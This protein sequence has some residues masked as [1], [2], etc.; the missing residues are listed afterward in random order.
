MVLFPSLSEYIDANTTSSNSIEPCTVLQLYEDTY[1]DFWNQ[2]IIRQTKGES[3]SYRQVT[4][5]AI[6]TEKEEEQGGNTRL[7]GR[8]AQIKN[9]NK[10][11]GKQP[12]LGIWNVHV[13]QSHITASSLNSENTTFLW[14]VDLSTPQ[15]VYASMQ[16]FLKAT[17]KYFDSLSTLSSSFG[18]APNNSS[19]EEVSEQIPPFTKNQLIIAAI[20]PPNTTTTTFEEKQAQCLLQ[21]HLH[22]FAAQIKATLVFVS[23]EILKEEDDA[24][25][26]KKNG[27]FVSDLSPIIHDLCSNSDEEKDNTVEF[28]HQDHDL[29]VI[30][31]V[32]LRNASCP[33][34]WDANTQD[35]QEVFPPTTEK[36]SNVLASP[37]KQAPNNKNDAWLQTLADS[38]GDM[39]TTANDDASTVVSAGTA[40]TKKSTSSVRRSTSAKSIKGSMRKST[41]NNSGD[42]VGSFF[43]DLLKK[44]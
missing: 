34:L 26:V 33:G 15:Q 11:G 21:Y 41:S 23:D 31:S 17:C 24:E 30:E 28:M 8:V 35:L 18:Q 13:N 6:C 38:L 10:L 1:I 32:M 19:E 2:Q 43:A 27:I 39:R 29:D 36:E 44:P 12:N 9:T 40:S 22:K 16:S 7:P 37:S 5:H 3:A 20:V 42:D 14:S 4:Y 25:D